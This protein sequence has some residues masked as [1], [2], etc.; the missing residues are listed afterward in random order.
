MGL[1]IKVVGL[2]R[3]YDGMFVA[4]EFDNGEKHVVYHPC[5]NHLK[6][7]LANFYRRKLLPRRMEVVFNRQ[8]DGIKFIIKTAGRKR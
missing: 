4:D 8:I 1:N 5:L 2:I 6:I 3:L 7:C